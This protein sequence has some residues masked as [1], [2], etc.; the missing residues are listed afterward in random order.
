MSMSRLNEKVKNYEQ[1]GKIIN[2]KD[3]MKDMISH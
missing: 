2:T 3:N 1:A